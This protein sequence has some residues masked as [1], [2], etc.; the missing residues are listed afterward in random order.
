MVQS[1]RMVDALKQALKTRGVSYAQVGDHLGLSLSSVKRLFASGALS[2][3]RL[4][5]V[6]DLAG[7]DLLE[8]ARLADA[9][10]LR[11]SSLTAAQER[12]LV[13]D[14]ALLLV[15]VCAMN[16]WSFEKILGRYRLGV[17]QLVALLARL[18]RMGLIELLP[19]NRIRLRVA[20]NFA[21][22][23]DGPIHRHFVARVQSEFLSGAFA[24]E[25]DLH[26]FAWGM[27]SAESATVLRTKMEELM[28]AF[29]DLTRGD[30]VRAGDAASGTCLLVALRQW[31]P[32]AF[33]A[34]RRPG[35]AA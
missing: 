17:P 2:L 20:R 21:W 7:L 24:P 9:R 4:E 25:R 8:L 16:R 31:E 23:P 1:Q 30:E 27:L 29:D 5:S 19:G 34:M 33:R 22:L 35:P 28:D 18:D 6:C 26:R 15:A 32:T 14:P 11:V 3:E 13:D 12:E 10:R